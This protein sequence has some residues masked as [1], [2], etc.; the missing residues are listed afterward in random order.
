[1]SFIDKF[2]GPWARR[3]VMAAV[4]AALLPGVVGLTGQSATAEAFSRPG[5]P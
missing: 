1:M 4:A 5:L 2:R 3:F